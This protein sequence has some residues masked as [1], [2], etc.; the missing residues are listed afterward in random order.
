[1]PPG[2]AS[3]SHL[4]GG[5]NVFS[6]AGETLAGLLLE[7]SP[8]A[9]SSKA[10]SDPPSEFSSWHDDASSSLATFSAGDRTI[11]VN[12][13]RARMGEHLKAKLE[14]MIRQRFE[15]YLRIAQTLQNE[16]GKLAAL[17]CE[18]RM[19]RSARDFQAR[20]SIS[21]NEDGTF[22]VYTVPD[23]STLPRSPAS[24]FGS[25]A[26]EDGSEGGTAAA[27]EGSSAG[28]QPNAQSAPSQTDDGSDLL[29]LWVKQVCEFGMSGCCHSL[30]ALFDFGYTAWKQLL[31]DCNCP[32]DAIWASRRTSQELS[33]G[34]IA[35]EEER[36]VRE[37]EPPQAPPQPPPEEPPAEEAATEESP[38]SAAA[39][40]ARELRPLAEIAQDAKLAVDCERYQQALELCTEGI[41][42]AQAAMLAHGGSCAASSSSTAPWPSSG[43]SNSRAKTGGA[44]AERNAGI[45]AGDAAVAVWELLSM[46]ASVQ[47][48][49]G[50]YSEALKDAEELIALQP[51][52]AEGYYWQS[53]ALRGLGRS[54]EALESL[55]S[56]LEYEP[57]NPLF[58]QAFTSL[59]EEISAASAPAT[60]A[61]SSRS[62][63]NPTAAAA[64]RPPAAAPSTAAAPAVAVPVLHGRRPR[65]RP[66]GDALSTTTQA[67]RLSSRSTT[68]TEVSAPLSHSSSNDSL[69][70]AG[71]AFDEAP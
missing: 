44:F 10:P 56:A 24:S 69:S 57:Q 43:A 39:A 36:P 51:T 27:Q 62:G 19:P 68:P 60:Q 35:E 6:A 11:T 12:M 8:A 21:C 46:R 71:A 26:G 70:M 15:D 45:D 67:T 9:R 48:R 53:T 42:Q 29:R 63:S 65:G 22:F 14:G 52:C 34:H 37:E 18:L 66:A 61:H 49:L 3:S 55:M 33:R 16:T 28:E 13:Q 32:P 2:A 23:F 41:A 17:E 30:T 5:G 54:Q 47:A 50:S 7:Q 20:T 40:A 4:G 38:A 59:F 1:M 58:Q 64:A 25:Q 31:A